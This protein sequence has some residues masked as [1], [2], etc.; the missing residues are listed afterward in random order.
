M[1]ALSAVALGAAATLWITSDRSSQGIDNRA[2]TDRATASALS[3]S[4]ATSTRSPESSLESP[5]RAPPPPP[6]Y[7]P[8]KFPDENSTGVP[9]GVS[10]IPT[11]GMTIV[12]DGTVIEGMHVK[13]RIIIDADDVTIR[14][15]L[16]QTQTNLYPI[17]IERD[18]TGTLIEDVEVDNQQGSGLGVF[19]KSE[20]TLR[21]ANIHS[22]EDGVRIEADN[23][24]IEDSYIH[25]L[26][27]MPGGHHDSIQIRKGD[28]ITIRR[29]NLQA[30]V[31][32]TDDPMNAAIQLGSLLGDDQV[33]NLRVVNNL[34]NG[35]NY[36]INGGKGMVDSGLYAYNYFGRDSRYGPVASLSEHEVWADTNRW[37]DT[38][39]P[40]PYN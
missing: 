20:G 29:N 35:G 28:D 33:S 24:T 15:T 27:R 34:L 23:V 22:A 19:F 3:G 38:G 7:R 26:H 36:T 30:Y 37:Y 39:E 32:N 8:P 25:S 18:T 13:G 21:R 1:L 17:T 4:S 12:E 6:T 9:D 40:V 14:S 10:L 31:A 5:V 11:E 2:D 16:V